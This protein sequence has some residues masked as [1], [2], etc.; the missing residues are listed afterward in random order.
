MD[1]TKQKTMSIWPAFFSLGLLILGSSLRGCWLYISFAMLFFSLL[2]TAI[3]F[4]V[5][6]RGLTLKSGLWLATLTFA[7]WVGVL[8]VMQIMFFTY[9]RGFHPWILLIFLPSIASPILCGIKT[10]QALKKSVYSPPKKNIAA[11]GAAAATGGVIGGIIGRRLARH[12][13]EFAI[14]VFIVLTS[15]I[16]VFFSAELVYLQKLYYIKKYNISL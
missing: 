2:C 14:V 5:C 10:H 15:V 3:V 1:E 6:W 9:L 11:K 13:S 7:E 16:N 12:D 8:H 4:I